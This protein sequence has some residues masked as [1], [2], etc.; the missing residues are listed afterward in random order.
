MPHTLILVILYCGKHA[1]P[2]LWPTLYIQK[3]MFFVSKDTVTAS[4][5]V[6]LQQPGGVPITG[7]CKNN[8]DNFFFAA[9]LC[10]NC[11]DH[12]VVFSL[13]F[14]VSTVFSLTI[15]VKFLFEKGKIPSI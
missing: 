15:I 6:E 5:T 3:I 10:N 4:N 1:V 2:F 8:F 12:L 14:L 7:T 9:D 13:V 11:K